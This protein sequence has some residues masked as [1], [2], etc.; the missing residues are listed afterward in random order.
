MIWGLLFNALY[1]RA[2]SP[3]RKKTENHT[4]VRMGYFWRATSVLIKKIVKGCRVTL[5]DRHGAEKGRIV[6]TE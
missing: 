2:M 5:S 3:L 6:T 4:T 1:L